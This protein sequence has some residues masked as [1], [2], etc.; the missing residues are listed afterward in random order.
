MNPLNAL[1]EARRQ[2]GD[3]EHRVAEQRYH[4]ETM[5]REGHDTQKAEALL[6]TFEETLGTMRERLEFKRREAIRSHSAEA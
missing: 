4:V 6:V 1:A 2:V 5:R 3:A